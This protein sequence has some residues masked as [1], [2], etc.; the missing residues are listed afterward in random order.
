[1]QQLDETF[2]YRDFEELK[3]SAARYIKIPSSI[4]LYTEMNSKR[5][6]VFTYLS[7]YKGLNDKLN[8]SVPLFL[9]WAGYKSDTHKG[10]INDSIID[11]TDCLSDLD[12]LYYSENRLTRTSCVEV[13]F[14]TQLV[15]DD[16]SCMSFAII[17]LDEIEK[18][19]QYKD[20][21]SKDTYLNCNTVLLV[22]AFLRHAI[23]R[24]PNKLKPEERSPEG[25]KSRRE[26]CIEAYADSYKEIGKLLDLSDRTVSKAVKILEEL[27]LIVVAEAY[28][29]KNELGGFNTPYTLFANAY[30]REKDMLLFTGEN[31]AIDEINRKAAKIRQYNPYFHI[32]K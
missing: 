14:N 15:F 2:E 24:T 6:S 29:I 9:E 7:I 22:F 17:Y 26:R 12:Y 27:G 32:K 1:M 8:F 5:V 10:G 3:G 31:Y 20:Y 30:K 11:V 25:I 19:M 28:H 4:I 16:C 23:F 21:N 18:I 13:K